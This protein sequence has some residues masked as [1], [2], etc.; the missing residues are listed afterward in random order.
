M[1]DSNNNKLLL[2][3]GNENDDRQG[4]PERWILPDGRAIPVYSSFNQMHMAS[5][6]ITCQSTTNQLPLIGDVDDP[7]SN[8]ST[9]RHGGQMQLDLMTDEEIPPRGEISE[10][11]ESN[12]SSFV[13]EDS[14]SL[15]IIDTL[16]IIVLVCVSNL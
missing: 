2:Q 16:I 9:D 10:Y 13:S 12:T 5:K 14:V 8:L 11:E 4:E 15:I 1:N 6:P 7:L 3:S